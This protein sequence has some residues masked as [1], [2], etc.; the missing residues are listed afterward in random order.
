MEQD[1]MQPTTPLRNF[2]A[3]LA[4]QRQWHEAN[5]Q[6][7]PQQAAAVHD[8]LRYACG[9]LR[10]PSDW[11][12]DLYL[13]HVGFPGEA[14]YTRGVQPTMYRTI[15]DDAYFLRLWDGPRDQ[16]SGTNICWPK[17]MAA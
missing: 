4:A 1:K 9:T 10:D 14:P 15:V 6:R 16:L 17:A 2:R 13:S 8:C 3:D 11:P 7:A 5:F 12:E